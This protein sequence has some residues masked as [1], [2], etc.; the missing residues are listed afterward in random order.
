MHSQK[1]TH[2]HTHTHTCMYI[3]M[4]H[5]TGVGARGGWVQLSEV[6]AVDVDAS[7]YMLDKK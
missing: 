1:H 5:G 7:W 2:T 4:D 6:W 3:G